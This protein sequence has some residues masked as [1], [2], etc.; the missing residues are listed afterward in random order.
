MLTTDPG[1][2]EPA[3]DPAGQASAAESRPSGHPGLTR[4]RL[5]VDEFDAIAA[6][7][8][9]L[10]TLRA[11]QLSR[12]MLLIQAL[13]GAAAERRPD[14]AGLAE[15]DASLAQLRA[16][17]RADRAEVDRLL[18]HP[19]IGAWGMGCLRLLF[20][21]GPETNRP[22]APRRRAGLGSGTLAAQLGCFG[23]LSAAAALLLGRECDVVAHALDGALAFPTLGLATVPGLSG[24]VRI[25]VTFPPIEQPPV[26]QGSGRQTP[27]DR[28]PD[29]RR[30]GPRRATLSVL[31]HSGTPEVL[32]RFELE[33]DA[34]PGDRAGTGTG[35]VH[36]ALAVVA[37]A[38]AAGGPGGPA[39][40]PLRTLVS[41]VDGCRL[42]VDLDD[43]DP[44]RSFN[45]VPPAPRLDDGEL[46]VWRRRLDEA[47][48]LLVT[49]HRGRASMIAS[50]LASLIPLRAPNDAEVLSAS[51]A[52]AFGAVSLT[53]PHSGLALA[54]SLIHELAHSRLSA[55]LGLVPL[56]EPDRRAVHYSPW[57]RDP[58]PVPGLTQGA[59]AF[60][61][62]TDFWNDHRSTVR[63][64]G[65]RLAQFEYAR[66]RAELPGVMATLLSSGVLTGLGERFVGG[67]RRGLAAIAGGDVP[68][69]V[70]ALADLASAEHRIT[71]R[72]RNVR[73]RA[74]FVAALG[75]AWRAG[76]PCPSLPASS[77]SAGG[78]PSD[79]LP[80]SG[81]PSSGGPG[82]VAAI[83]PTPPDDLAPTA[84]RFVA[85]GRL[86][87]SYLRL[88]EPERFEQFLEE[89]FRLGPVLP[90]ASPADLL[91]LTG[92]TTGASLLYHDLIVAEPQRIDH[93]AGLVLSR[94]RARG[95]ADPPVCRPEVLMA[96]HAH[97]RAEG[98]V[99]APIEL[100]D[101][102]AAQTAAPASAAMSVG[103]RAGSHSGDGSNTKST[104]TPSATSRTS[105]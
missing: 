37:E 103:G 73:P 27:G 1:P 16:S 48:E 42:V 66:W 68:E 24:W 40:L 17:H 57:R 58:R 76:Q 30:A 82:A 98:A 33:L 55:L 46:A 35:V 36:R 61:A 78:V 97:L 91:L 101:W 94:R 87:L 22:E 83:G 71:W 93:W 100:A 64:A 77:I 39:W 38:G 6:G 75:A 99:A 3:G 41:E 104:R 102:M 51:S 23:T 9:D 5:A 60:L 10:A 67:M 4:H 65:G 81:V 74:A 8:G 26:G 53:L 34:R 84:P 7:H 50:A 29:E 95:D 25:R 86:S 45:H 21:H 79:G 20:G 14:L 72:L 12:R 63:G 92:Q 69:D 80:S 90:A 32:A 47:W 59:F 49:H 43:I 105:G 89:P 56:F 62:L 19:Q 96:L 11:G 31:A 52:D 88:R 2:T 15:L 70:V 44:F 13:A 28:P 85:P 54:A 18:L